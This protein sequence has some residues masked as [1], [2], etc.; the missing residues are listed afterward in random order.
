LLTANH[1]KLIPFK[2]KFCVELFGISFES[3][4]V[5][6][7]LPPLFSLFMNRLRDEWLYSFLIKTGNLK[8]SFIKRATFPLNYSKASEK[9]G[10]KRKNFFPP[11]SSM[12]ITGHQTTP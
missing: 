1:Q 10:R 12:P 7:A 5:S 2:K 3:S 6:A 8:R 11:C 4:R 9:S